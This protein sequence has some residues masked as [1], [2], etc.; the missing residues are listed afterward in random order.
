MTSI[1]GAPRNMSRGFVNSKYAGRA[2][3][4]AEHG[5]AMKWLN[6][7]FVPH[8][9]QP[10]ERHWGGL[11]IALWLQSIVLEES[12]ESST[13]KGLRFDPD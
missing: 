5:A 7:Y 2:S 6:E 11:A 12:D 13:T 3:T 8:H 1:P 4:Y 10:L 9:D